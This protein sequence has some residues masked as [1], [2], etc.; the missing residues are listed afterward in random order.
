M[1]EPKYDSSN[2]AQYLYAK[3]FGRISSQLNEAWKGLNSKLDDKKEDILN[4]GRIEIKLNVDLECL[5]NVIND[6]NE[7][8]FVQKYCA[9]SLDRILLKLN[10][11]DVNKF[12]N[13]I[14]FQIFKNL[15]VKCKEKQ[16]DNII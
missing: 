6:D 12:I 2:N 15:L 4:L 8:S 16:F 14:S 13:R 1:N 10:E 3:S 9:Y 7:N 5:M 11:R